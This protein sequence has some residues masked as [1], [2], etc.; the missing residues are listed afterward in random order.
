MILVHKMVENVSHTFLSIE[1]V[2]QLVRVL[3]CHVKGRGFDPR[4][5]RSEDA[6]LEKEESLNVIFHITVGAM[7]YSM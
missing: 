7:L 6:S 3:A 4:R 2:A 5:P 1:D